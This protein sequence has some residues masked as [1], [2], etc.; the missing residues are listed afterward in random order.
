[1]SKPWFGAKRYGIGLSPT[2]WEGWASSAG[3]LVLVIALPLAVAVLGLP[4]WAGP[5]ADVAITA[6]FFLL[7][8]LKNDRSPWR[9]RWGGR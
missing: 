3:Y 9:W 7:V 5:A 8:A 2:S 4:R 6:A 1:M